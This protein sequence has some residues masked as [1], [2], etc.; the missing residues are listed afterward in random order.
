MDQNTQNYKIK[1]E[2]MTLIADKLRRVV[3]KTTPLTP[4]EIAY[5][6]D[7]IIFTPQ[8]YASN[9]FKV[10]TNYFHSNPYAILPEIQIANIQNDF[11]IDLE[12]FATNING[13][14]PDIPASNSQDQFSVSS[15]CFVTTATGMLQN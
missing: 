10:E 2:T 1:R 15:A 13:Y 14:L 11:N 9:T 5:Y 3:G 7:R 12:N 8:S 6:I 4:A